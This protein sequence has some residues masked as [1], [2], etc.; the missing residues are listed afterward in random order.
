MS[1][2]IKGKSVNKGM[3][4]QVQSFLPSHDVPAGFSSVENG[5]FSNP[6]LET[7]GFIEK[8]KV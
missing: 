8:S 6:S 5:V 1:L 7:P 3:D 4:S 2:A